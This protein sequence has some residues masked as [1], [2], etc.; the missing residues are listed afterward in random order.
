MIPQRVEA[1]VGRLLARYFRD[2][3]LACD[4]PEGAL[5]WW[6]PQDLDINEGMVVTALE[7]LVALGALETLTAVDGRVRYRC[8]GGEAARSVLDRHAEIGPSDP[9]QWLR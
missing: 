5:R 2:N 1:D 3:P 8:R 7:N 4:T 6:L 9:G